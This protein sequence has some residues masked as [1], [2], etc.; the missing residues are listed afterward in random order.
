MPSSSIS[1]SLLLLLLRWRRRRLRW[2]YDDDRTDRGVARRGSLRADK[3][4]TMDIVTSSIRDRTSAGEYRGGLGQSSEEEDEDILAQEVEDILGEEADATDLTDPQP[5]SRI[6]S[7]ASPRLCLRLPSSADGPT[8]LLLSMLQCSLMVMVKNAELRPNKS[9][10]RSGAG[11]GSRAR[12]AAG[13]GEAG[14]HPISNHPIIQSAY[15]SIQSQNPKSSECG[16]LAPFHLVAHVIVR[17]PP[18][19]CSTDHGPPF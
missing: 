12:A 5:S 2:R 16:G 10:K 11:S 9:I 14:A 8:L 13:S 17:W 18:S 3:A 4:S 19:T 6:M 7:L 15:G 1:L